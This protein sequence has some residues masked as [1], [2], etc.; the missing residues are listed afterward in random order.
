MSAASNWQHPQA[1]IDRLSQRFYNQLLK[2][3]TS[4]SE[5]TSGFDFQMTP[6]QRAQEEWAIENMGLITMH[7]FEVSKM[8]I[9]TA[10]MAHMPW[11]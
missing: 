4:G 3:M 2:K 6:D 9:I 11:F 8:K 7:Q 1:N 10:V 5:N